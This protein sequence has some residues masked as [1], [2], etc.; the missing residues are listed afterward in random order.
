MNDLNAQEQL[1]IE[2]Q[3]AELIRNHQ[4][5]LKQQAIESLHSTTK[6]STTAIDYSSNNPYESQ[7]EIRQFKS[8]KVKFTQ[9]SQLPLRTK[10]K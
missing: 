9:N 3:E 7:S 4:Q 10:E 8:L 6:D 2:R 5:R 1:R